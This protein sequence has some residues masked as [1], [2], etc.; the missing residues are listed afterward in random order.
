MSAKPAEILHLHGHDVGIT[1]PEKVLFPEDG[2]T[3]GDLVRYFERVSSWMLPHLRGWPLAMQR[4]PDGIDGFGFFQKAAAKYYPDW[5][6]KVTVPKAGGTVTHVI[7][8]DR[9][10]LAY[11][12]NQACLTPHIWLSQADKPRQ[13]DRMVFDLDPPNAVFTGVIRG[14]N[15][16][17][18]ILERL[19]LPAYIKAT[20][21]RGLHVVVPLHPDWDFDEVRAFARQAGEMVV[22]R[23]PS[24]FT[25]EQ[26][27]NKRGGRVFIDTNRNAYAQTAVAPYAIRARDGAPAA[28]PLDWPELRKK[29]FRP[30]GVTLKTISTRLEKIED[31]WK[32]FYRRT[33]T[34][35]KAARQ[36]ERRRQ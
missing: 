34:L 8:D 33:A 16:L 17:R 32:D 26:H 7:C 27:K 21:S 10:T 12:A 28:V 20:G 22:N 11:L 3:K 1:R 5:I 35:D 9:A 4:F 36:M 30:D 14:A 18:E 31:P 15:L 25:M 24:L 2:I 13:P 29:N 6:R 19:E 23:D